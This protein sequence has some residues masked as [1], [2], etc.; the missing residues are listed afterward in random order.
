[1]IELIKNS[2][3]Y[4]YR[5]EL[6]RRIFK[7]SPAG[8]IAPKLSYSLFF[9]NSS[10]P[11]YINIEITN[12]CNFKCIMCPNPTIPI[13]KKGYMDLWLFKKI[14]NEIDQ[15]GPKNL[16][17]VKQGEALLHPKV[18]DF[19]NILRKTKHHHNVM[20]V[21]NGS[22][23]NQQ[24][25][26]A[27]INYKI[28][29]VNISIDSL[30]S[31]VFYTIRRYNLDKIL[32]NIE[33]LITAKKRKK[34]KLPRLSV[35]TVV[36]NENINEMKDIRYYFKSKKI[37][38][39]VQKY[40]QSPTGHDIGN[41]KWTLGECNSSKRYPCAHV[42][43]NLVINYDG[44]VSLC[45]SDWKSSYPVADVN[46]KSIED[47]WNSEKY[48]FVRSAHMSGEYRKIPICK[49]CPAWQ[50]HP[51]IFFPWNYQRG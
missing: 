8:W 14:M 37:Q 42:F 13:E 24:H 18:L 6:I 22:M 23:L 9:K 33:N 7:E 16:M 25:I 38:H 10:F 34:S 30:N 41:K 3:S 46:K 39:T 51:D 27:L 35:N 44:T 47:I 11:P 15:Q 40:D 49:K 17:F 19:L 48:G 32:M 5:Q 21:T 50:N 26:E 1:M 20:W 28:D 12:V 29:E 43:T 31:D 36:L 45:C 2:L 4:L